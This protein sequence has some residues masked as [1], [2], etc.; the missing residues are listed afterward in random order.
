MFHS[1]VEFMSEEEKMLKKEYPNSA[2]FNAGYQGQYG[3][4]YQGP[5]VAGVGQYVPIDPAHMNAITTMQ[6]NLMTQRLIQQA[7]FQEAHKQA[8]YAGMPQG[9]AYNE[10]YGNPYGLEALKHVGEKRKMEEGLPSSLKRA[11]NHKDVNSI[12]DEDSDKIRAIISFLERVER[13]RTWSPEETYCLAQVIIE[14][15]SLI[16]QVRFK[17]LHQFFTTKLK[18]H[19]DL[20]TKKTRQAFWARHCRIREKLKVPKYE[21]IFWGDKSL[22][23]LKEEFKVEPT[24]TQKS[25][26]KKQEETETES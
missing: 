18:M 5:Y 17:E 9:I 21:A 13:P 7:Q 11:R 15:K 24:P 23:E 8:F 14:N 20:E 3:A 12:K 1:N 25:K 16:K 19:F 6:H 10:M 26:K 2:M 22:E 4:S